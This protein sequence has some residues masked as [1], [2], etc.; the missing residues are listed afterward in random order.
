M[1]NEGLIIPER[2]RNIGQFTV[3]RILPFRK[4]RNVGPFVFIDH[5][6]PKLIKPGGYLG[7][8]QHPHIG[9]ST[10]TYLFEGEVEHKDST[11]ATQNIGPRDVG[12]MTAGKAVTHTERTPEHLKTEYGFFMHGY[13]IWVALPKEKEEM[14]PRFDFVS[15]E[16]LPKWEQNGIQ[17]TLVA[18]QG[19]GRTS[20]L[21]VHSPLFL[22]ELKASE[23]SI[24]ETQ[25]E[26]K[27]ELGVLIVSGEVSCEQETISAGNTIVSENA[28]N[29]TFTLSNGAHIMLFGGEAF[30]EERHLFWNFC[31]SSKELIEEAKLDWEH[32]RFPKVP[33]DNTYIPLPN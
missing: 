3:G 18:G 6:G 14:E 26:L 4:K 16:K 25:S 28:E 17:F 29:L 11:G 23:A 31:S 30:S 10:L 15:A 7:V 19:F 32:K 8:D 9:I 24:F 33:G 2:S 13:Q 20:P 12:F 21:P 27:G 5:M 1:S 22:L